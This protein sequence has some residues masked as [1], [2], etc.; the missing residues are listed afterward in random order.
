VWSGDIRRRIQDLQGRLVLRIRICVNQAADQF[1]VGVPRIAKIDKKLAAWVHGL[2]VAIH[3]PPYFCAR[4]L[5]VGG[6]GKA[7]EGGELLTEVRS[8]AKIVIPAAH[9]FARRGQAHAL[10]VDFQEPVVAQIQEKLM[11]LVKLTLERP[12]PPNCTAP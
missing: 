5:R 12:I 6:G 4:G 7:G 3:Q 2:G 1:V 8:R 10:A 11:V 9:V